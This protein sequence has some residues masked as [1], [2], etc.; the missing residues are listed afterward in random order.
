LAILFNAYREMCEKP[1]NFMVDLNLRPSENW[2][3]TLPLD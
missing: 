1:W 2:P 3:G